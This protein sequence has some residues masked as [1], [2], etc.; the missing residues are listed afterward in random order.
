MRDLD[1][2]LILE[3][4]LCDEHQNE[5]DTLVLHELGVRHGAVRVDLAVINGVITGYEIKSERDT[6]NRL[7]TQIE[8][9]SQALDFIHIVV[10]KSH[11]E[12]ALELVPIW[13]GI[14]I[15]SEVKGKIQLETSREATQNPE[16]N[17][18]AI[19]EFLWREEALLLLEE[20]GWDK[21][22]RKRPRD[23]L[24]ERLAQN[25][26]LNEL[27]D[28]VRQILKT[29]ANWRVDLQQTQGGA[30]IPQIANS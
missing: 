8:I 30:R 22:I 27:Q 20:R 16:L 12:K 11:F 5:T 9:Y 19:A 28:A 25:M 13:W 6:L 2:R 21:D 10:G 1:I 4:T 14:V 18:I 17:P 7:P 15:A 29:R 3:K 23:V 26:E 24:Y